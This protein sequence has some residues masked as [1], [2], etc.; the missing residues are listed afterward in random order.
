MCVAV[1]CQENEIV[2][3]IFN[4]YEEFPGCKLTA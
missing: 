4:M 1:L 2:G 3:N